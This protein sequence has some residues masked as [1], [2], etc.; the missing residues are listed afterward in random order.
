MN[1]LARVANRLTS[2]ASGRQWSN[3]SEA[4][5]NGGGQEGSSAQGLIVPIAA[6]ARGAPRPGRSLASW[7]ILIKLSWHASGVGREYV[8]G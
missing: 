8:G 2:W 1:G 3:W 6:A 7:F 4:A 5:G